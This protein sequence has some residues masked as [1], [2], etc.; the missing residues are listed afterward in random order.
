MPRLS[1]RDL[2]LKLQSAGLKALLDTSPVFRK[3]MWT[4]MIEAGIFYPTYRQGSPHGTSYQEG[5]RALG[6]EILHMLKAAHEGTLGILEREGDLI[7][8]Q[9]GAA[10]PPGED[11]DAEDDDL[12]P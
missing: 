2:A 8:T 1:N 7:A 5:R 11:D 3:F 9:T 12:I 4:L 10:Q 6:L